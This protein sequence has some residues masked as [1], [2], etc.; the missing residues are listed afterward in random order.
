M[1]AG[2]LSERVSEGAPGM[3]INTVPTRDLETNTF[4]FRFT[5]VFWDHPDHVFAVSPDDVLPVPDPEYDLLNHYDQLL[6]EL[7]YA[8]AE[9]GSAGLLKRVKVDRD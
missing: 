2:Q 7:S 1:R 4:R 9:I 6:H 5:V 3:I 8:L